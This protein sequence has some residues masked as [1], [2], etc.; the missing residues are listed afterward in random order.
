[1]R[2]LLSFTN[3]R[4]GYDASLLEL[5]LLFASQRTKMHSMADMDMLDRRALCA[6]RGPLAQ[7]SREPQR[8]S[9]L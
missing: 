2:T 7:Y 8:W 6:Q 1:M 3:F 9:F 4:D 5:S